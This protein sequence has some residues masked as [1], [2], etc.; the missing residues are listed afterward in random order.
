[1]ITLLL[2]GVLPDQAMFVYDVGK[3]HPGFAI[4]L[5]FF[6]L[7]STLTVMNM[8]VGVLVEVVSVVSSAE[9]EL[10]TV[11]FVKTKLVKMLEDKQFDQ[12]GNKRINKCE[13]EALLLNPRAARILQEI[14]VDVVGLVDFSDHIFEDE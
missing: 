1:M 7:L 5:L 9:K 11:S 12:D 8:L 2:E 4:F 3:E 13:F 6:I 10:L 14:G